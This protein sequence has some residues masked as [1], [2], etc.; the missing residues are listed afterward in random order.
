V[1]GQRQQHENKTRRAG[2]WRGKE[3]DDLGGNRTGVRRR[4]NGLLLVEHGVELHQSLHA[5]LHRRHDSARGQ[6]YVN[7]DGLRREEGMGRR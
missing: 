2:H 5:F 6:H 3:A 1:H 7:E 4:C